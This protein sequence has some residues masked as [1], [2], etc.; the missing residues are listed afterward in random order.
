M[1][2][3]HEEDRL[4]RKPYILSLVAAAGLLGAGCGSSSKPAPTAPVTSAAVGQQAA[5]SSGSTYNPKIDPAKFSSNVT[6]RY[7][8][9]KPGTT[10]VFTGQ[11]DGAPQHVVVRVTNQK[12]TVLGV[13]CVVVSDVVTVNQTLAEKTTDWYAQDDKGN[14][15][16]FGEDTKEYKNGVVTSTHGTWEAGVDN[17]KPGIVVQGSPKVGGFYRQEFRPGQAE[18]QAR[19]VSLTGKEHVPAGTYGNVMVTKDIDPLNPDKVEHKFYAPGAGPVHVIRIGSAH[20]EEIK[21]VSK[22]P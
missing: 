3:T 5:G 21:L 1:V 22:R 16:Y 7:W 11:K 17:A 8:P 13:H 15:W 19:I 12:K 20:R 2:P 9:L 14:V 4:S 10:W 18:D 6:N